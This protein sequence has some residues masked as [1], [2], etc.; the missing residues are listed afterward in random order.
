MSHV[1]G[2]EEEDKLR[3]IT[4][5]EAQLESL[6]II[7]SGYVLIAFIST[8]LIVKKSEQVRTSRWPTTDLPQ[9]RLAN[10]RLVSN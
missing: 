4:E 1:I 3:W 8:W 9:I 6:S 5:R 7:S 10:Y 2:Q